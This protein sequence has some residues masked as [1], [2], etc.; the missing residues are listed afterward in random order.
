MLSATRIQ[1]GDVLVAGLHDV[2]EGNQLFD[3]TPDVLG[4]PHDGGPCVRVITNARSRGSLLGDNLDYPGAPGFEC[5]ANGADMH[6]GEGLPWKHARRDVPQKVKLIGRRAILGDGR[7]RRGGAGK[8]IH[9]INQ[10]H[11]TLKNVLGNDL[12]PGVWSHPGGK[13]NVVPESTTANRDVEGAPPGCLGNRVTSNDAIR[14][15]FTHYQER[16]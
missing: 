16:V 13:Y 10:R 11:A 5:C 15:G 1:P 4:V 14:E 6:V 9:V 7:T 2:G 8:S 3:S 12:A